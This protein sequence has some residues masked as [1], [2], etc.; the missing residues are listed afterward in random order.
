VSGLKKF[1]AGIR[2]RLMSWFTIILALVLFIFSAFVYTRQAQDLQGDNLNRLAIKARQLENLFQFEG[3]QSMQDVR[4]LMPAL[5]SGGVALVQEDE[6]LVVADPI[7]QWTSQLGPVNSTDV[8]HMVA[9]AQL[10][11]QDGQTHILNYD[12]VS[13]AT[14]QAQQYT[15]LVV[16][17][18]ARGR[19]VGYM[20]LGRPADS[21]GQLPRLMATLALAS[22]AV[23]A[24]AAGVGYW[25]AGRVLRPVKVIT[26]TARQI[27]D[28]DL[29]KR[30]NL[31]T[32]DELGELANTFDDML[33]RLQAAFERQRQFTTDASH[34][35]RTPL[36][37]IGLETGRMLTTR[38]KPEEYEQ[39]L[40][41]IQSENDHMTRLVN[42][43]LVLARMEAGQ[44][45][46]EQ[47]KIDLSD[48]ALEVVERLSPLAAAK[49]VRLD[50]GEL[51]ETPVLGDRGHLG[52]MVSNL[53][54]NAI[55]YAPATNGVVTVESGVSGQQAWVKVADNGD[56]IA[57]EDRPHIFER[58]YRA[59][60]SRSRSEDK[61]DP[62]GSGLGLAIVRW[63]AQAH[64]G[65]ASLESEPGSGAVFKVTLPLRA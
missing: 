33:A 39:V 19:L 48:V 49:G 45:N 55:K 37:I 15:F 29:S 64:G 36:T 20:L 6:V 16:P 57:L 63:I 1:V 25:L 47:E 58:F 11:V 59:D 38:R 21:T 31:N 10:L 41:T 34:E 40:Q 62:G 8:Q 9:T 51:P 46:L 3:L 23:L 56:G 26:R 14:K 5:V 61:N 2:F 7:T 44:I 27:S 32:S 17:V 65:D 24:G 12:L 13:T 52:Q 53:V 30:L 22:L 28:T 43:L 18:E 60:K 54:S 50:V 4:Q 42:D 35:L